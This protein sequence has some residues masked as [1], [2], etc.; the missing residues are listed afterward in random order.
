MSIRSF[1]ALTIEGVTVKASYIYVH[2]LAP[3]KIC[4]IVPGVSGADLTVFF[5]V[6]EAVGLTIR[7]TVRVHDGFSFHVG[8]W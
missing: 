7:N 6:R 5:R 3:T 4:T 8:K 2:I 1:G